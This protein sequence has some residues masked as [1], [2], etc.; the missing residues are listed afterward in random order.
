MDDLSRKT[1]FFNPKYP[2]TP[3]FIPLIFWCGV[4]V[5]VWMAIGS[6]LGLGMMNT[7]TIE[8]YASKNLV[9]SDLGTI[10]QNLNKEYISPAAFSHFIGYL[11]IGIIARAI[12]YLTLG[13]LFWFVICELIAGFFYI[14]KNIETI[15]QTKTQS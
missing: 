11:R 14:T 10:Y 13:P 4:I 15:K 9:S 1:S 7:S 8:N 6:F 3:T 12:A 5:C 2:L